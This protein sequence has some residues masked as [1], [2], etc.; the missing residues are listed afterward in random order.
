MRGDE[1]PVGHAKDIAEGELVV[2]YP[3]VGGVG[4][5]HLVGAVHGGVAGT[6][7]VG[8][9]FVQDEIATGI[10]ATRSKHVELDAD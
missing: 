5:D 7:H 3:V 8:C 1:P 2:F 4:I 9:E 10:Q 6:K